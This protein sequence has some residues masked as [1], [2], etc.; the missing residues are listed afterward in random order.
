MSKKIKILIAVLIV[1]AISGSIA[2]IKHRVDE[3]NRKHEEYLARVDH[4]W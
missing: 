1:L 3:E 4:A 2:I